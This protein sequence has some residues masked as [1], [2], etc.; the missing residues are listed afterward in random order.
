MIPG[1]LNTIWVPV[2]R[3]LGPSVNL[4]VPCF[5]RALTRAV[6]EVRLAVL[7]SR[8]CSFSW[9]MR[10]LTSG[11]GAPQARRLRPGPH[12]FSHA[13]RRATD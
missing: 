5:V 10:S 8:L 11:G 3:L 6:N 12:D 9:F 7:R 1:Q 13:P 4:T 2:G